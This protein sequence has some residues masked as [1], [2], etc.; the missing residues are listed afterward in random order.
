MSFWDQLGLSNNARNIIR[1][2]QAAPGS[3]PGRNADPEV[4]RIDDQIAGNEKEIGRLYGV[5]GQK[6]M[7]NYAQDPLPALKEDVQTIL[8]LK[9]SNR[10]LSDKRDE[11][12][13]ICKCQACGTVVDEDAVFCKKCGTKIIRREPAMKP[14]PGRVCPGCGAP[15]KEDDVFCMN[16]GTRISQEPAGPAHEQQPAGPVH[17]QQPAGPA[18]EQQPAG[19]VLEDQ[20]VRPM[21][22][23]SAEECTILISDVPDF[24]FAGDSAP[25]GEVAKE[26]MGEEIIAQEQPVKIR[27]RFCQTELN[28]DAEFCF[29]C[30][31]RVK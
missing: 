29:Y 15:V 27:C 25:A 30:G 6:Y 21:Q 11:I 9:D 8:A 13:G 7:E 4:G 18:H 19:P 12:L 26:V 20:P 14:A 5:I 2:G 17:E 16:C 1:P 10:Q 23:D 3:A 24:D 28:P 22:S 31:G